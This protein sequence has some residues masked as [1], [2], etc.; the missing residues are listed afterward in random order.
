MTFAVLILKKLRRQKIRTP[1][2][3]AGFSISTVQEDER[4][5]SARPAEVAAAVT[6]LHNLASVDSNALSASAR[7]ALDVA[8]H[9]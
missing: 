5:R 3:A 1:R 7:A 6:V 4:A 9:A 8:A 2:T